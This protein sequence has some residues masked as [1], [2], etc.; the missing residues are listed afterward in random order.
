[1]SSWSPKK[2]SKL[3][4]SAHKRSMPGCCFL[5]SEGKRWCVQGEWEVAFCAPCS[6]S[7]QLLAAGYCRCSEVHVDSKSIGG[8]KRKGK[9][10][11]KKRKKIALGLPNAP[12]PHLVWEDP[13]PQTV[14]GQENILQ[15]QHNML[16][17]FGGTSLGVCPWL[18]IEVGEMAFHLTQNCHPVV[19]FHAKFSAVQPTEIL[20]GPV[21]PQDWAAVDKDLLHGLQ[22]PLGPV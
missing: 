5:P 7:E 17:L 20:E 16:A 19:L 6:S 9:T 22:A 11:R 10:R 1:M 4:P 15:K 18:L 12:K 8:T 3:W 2:E 13:K 21:P 14:G